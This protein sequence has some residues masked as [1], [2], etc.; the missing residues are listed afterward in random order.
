MQQ[1]LHGLRLSVTWQKHQ[2]GYPSRSTFISGLSKQVISRAW[3]LFIALVGDGKEWARRHRLTPAAVVAALLCSTWR[4]RVNAASAAAAL[5]QRR[6]S[7]VPIWNVLWLRSKNIFY[8][9][10]ATKQTIN[11]VWIRIML[12][13][14]RLLQSFIS[15]KL[16]SKRLVAHPTTTTTE[17][18]RWS[19]S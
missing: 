1:R 2:K 19:Q 11:L 13:V 17:R 9:F 4:L 7:S 5:H 14:N 18:K 8:P 16:F 15:I 12:H 10:F 6:R 3:A